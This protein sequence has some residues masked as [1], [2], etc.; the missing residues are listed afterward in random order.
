MSKYKIVDKYNG[1]ELKSFF[2][3]LDDAKEVLNCYKNDFFD[4]FINRNCEFTKII[5]PSNYI[6]KLDGS[7][8]VWEDP[9][10]GEREWISLEDA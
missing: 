7:N 2:H 1:W 4:N 9:E 6:L 10:G 8:W 5:V 3:S